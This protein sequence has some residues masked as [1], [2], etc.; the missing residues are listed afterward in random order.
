MFCGPD[1]MRS[2][3]SFWNFVVDLSSFGRYSSVLS[4]SNVSFIELFFLEEDD[5]L[6]LPPVIFS[7]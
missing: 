1:K 5:L 3:V 4:T 6:D 2:A 7:H